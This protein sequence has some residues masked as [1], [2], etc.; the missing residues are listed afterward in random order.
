MIF[1]AT[2]RQLAKTISTD[3]E[4]LPNQFVHL[5]IFAIRRTLTLTINQWACCRNTHIYVQYRGDWGEGERYSIY[6][7]LFKSVCFVGQCYPLI[8]T[9]QT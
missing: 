5:Y 3:V 7:C 1:A 6:P 9:E 8:Y 4:H 2:R